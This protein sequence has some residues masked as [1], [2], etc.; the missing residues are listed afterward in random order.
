MASIAGTNI[1]YASY[2]N[3]VVGKTSDYAFSTVLTNFKTTLYSYFQDN[4]DDTP[5]D[6]DVFHVNFTSGGVPVIGSKL[7]LTAVTVPS[8]SIRIPPFTPPFWRRGRTCPM[9]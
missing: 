3:A 5:D 1:V 6:A 2:R 7:A 8:K 4:A 9:S